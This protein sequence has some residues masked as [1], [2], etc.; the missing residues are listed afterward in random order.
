MIELMIRKRTGIIPPT[1]GE[2]MQPFQAMVI[3]DPAIP[4]VY[5]GEDWLDGLGLAVHKLLRVS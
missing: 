4:Q 3:V 2:I 1:R 5:G